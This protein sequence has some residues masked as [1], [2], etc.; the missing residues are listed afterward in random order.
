C[1]EAALER[2]ARGAVRCLDQELGLARD[3]EV[4]A[5]VVERHRLHLYH[6]WGE[7]R[8]SETAGPPLHTAAPLLRPRPAAECSSDRA[9]RTSTDA[10]SHV[11]STSGGAPSSGATR[12][13]C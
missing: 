8:A 11:P 1:S 2:V 13:G 7:K 5:V 10:P 4:L 9:R 3:G 6:R 12:A